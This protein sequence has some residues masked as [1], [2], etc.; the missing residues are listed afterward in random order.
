MHE[1]INLKLL[2]ANKWL[3]VNS[4]VSNTR[5]ADNKL[6]RPIVNILNIMAPV[7]GILHRQYDHFPFNNILLVNQATSSSPRMRG[8]FISGHGRVAVSFF[9][10]SAKTVSENLT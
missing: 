3:V 10:C 7:I 2:K 9:F 1:F 5:F 4:R 8:L 6:F